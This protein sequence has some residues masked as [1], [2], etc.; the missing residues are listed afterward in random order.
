M[1]GDFRDVLRVFAQGRD[2]DLD[3]L[4]AEVEVCTKRTFTNRFLEVT[5]GGGHDTDVDGDRLAASNPLEGLAFEDAE[6]FRLDLG[7]HLPDFVEEQG[8]VRRLFEL[9]RLLAGR[10]GEGLPFRDRT[11]RF[12]AGSRSARRS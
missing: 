11:V 7:A 12:R 8:S 6:E 3:H 5:V 4:Q 9:A 1:L 2:V 10:T